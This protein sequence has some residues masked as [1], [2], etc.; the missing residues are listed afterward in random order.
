MADID[1]F[2]LAASD[3]PVK[4]KFNLGSGVYECEFWL[5]ERSQYYT[6]NIRN[7]DGDILY[8]TNLAYGQDL[9]HAVV[10][11]LDYTIQLVP[12]DVRDFTTERKIANKTV[13]PENLGNGVDL[14]AIAI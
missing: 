14:L 2:P 12:F 5:N 13:T 6:C 1:F 4:K 11:G 9:I 8:T 7:E 3:V 10:E